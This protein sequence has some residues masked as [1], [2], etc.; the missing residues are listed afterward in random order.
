MDEIHGDGLYQYLVFNH[1]DEV[2][3]INVLNIKEILVVPRITR[4][5]R[6]PA[7]MT[8][9]INLRGNVIPV[10]DLKLKFGHGATVATKD[11]SIIVLEIENIF[12]DGDT[13]KFTVGIFNDLVQNV[14]TIEPSRIEKPPRIGISIDTACISGM[15]RV[16]GKYVILL[17]IQKILTEKELIFI[18]N[19]EGAENE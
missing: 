2:F 6:M 14:I 8:G 5:P 11:T 1:G 10:L 3:A 13:Q 18:Q 9:V 17:N 4:V 16:E 15:A 7:F 12:S 19:G